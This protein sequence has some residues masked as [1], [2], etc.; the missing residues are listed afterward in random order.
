VAEVPKIVELPC[1][2]E[3]PPCL[4]QVADHYCTN[5]A[6]YEVGGV[7]LCARHAG[8]AAINAILGAA[9]RILTCSRCTKAK[10][11]TEFGR[12]KYSPTGRTSMC[13]LCKATYMKERRTGRAAKAQDLSQSKKQF[14]RRKSIAKSRLSA[15]SRPGSRSRKSTASS[16][17]TTRPCWAAKSTGSWCSCRPG[18]ARARWGPSSCRR[19][20]PGIPQ[21]PDP[22]DRP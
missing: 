18:P 6:R 5:M 4:M 15:R 2:A 13:L 1:G 3:P 12:D 8:I 9:E 11:E 20:G 19:C 7:W 21:R 10:P 14:N 22:P 17:R 16:R